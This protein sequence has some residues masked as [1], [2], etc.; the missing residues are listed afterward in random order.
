MAVCCKDWAA[1]CIDCVDGWAADG[2]SNESDS[3]SRGKLASQDAAS[4]ETPSLM[5]ETRDERG[6]EGGETGDWSGKDLWSSRQSVGLAANW[7]RSC[8]VSEGSA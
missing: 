2:L 3:V 6:V 7:S 5:R 1:C 8:A 4:D